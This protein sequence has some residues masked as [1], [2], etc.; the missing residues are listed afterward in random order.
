M[1]EKRT[2]KIEL[3]ANKH[4]SDASHEHIELAK[5][6]E[7]VAESPS[8]KQ[9]KTLEEIRQDVE[10]SSLSSEQLKKEEL[11][12]LEQESSQAFVQK[13]LK[14]ITLKKTISKIQTQLPASER[15]FSK[16]VHSPV[17]DKLSNVGEKTIAR[18]IGILGGGALA[19]LGSLFSTYFSRRFGM[20]YNLL[21][22]AIV[23][24]VG[25]VSATILELLY[26]TVVKPR[27]SKI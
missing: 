5:H 7:K 3:A 9:P 13:E 21:M 22:F 12:E 20:S 4:E 23:F 18:P 11:K 1:S 2:H 10:K 27:S 6:H 24:L 26:K 16:V 25:Y 15:A 17:I 8:E 14:N 19:L